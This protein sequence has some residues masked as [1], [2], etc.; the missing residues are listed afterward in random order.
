LVSGFE[1]LPVVFEGLRAPLLCECTDVVDQG[2]VA[3]KEEPF[4]FTLLVV[5]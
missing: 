1:R 5:V 4:S 3:M 2:I